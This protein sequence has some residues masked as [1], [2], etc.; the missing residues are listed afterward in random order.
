MARKRAVAPW[1]VGAAIVVGV[2]VCFS[3][4]LIS[5]VFGVNANID[6]RLS[7]FGAIAG[8]DIHT[9]HTILLLLTIVVTAAML[10]QTAAM[11]FVIGVTTMRGRRTEVALRR[12]SGVLRS[13]LIAEFSRSML[14]A[15]V[16][17]GVVG[18]LCGIVLGG[19]LR[20][21]T[22]LPVTFMP[23]TLLAPFPVTVLI[24]VAATIWP[25]WLAANASPALLRKQ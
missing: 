3:V 1:Q 4:L 11:T 23:I 7:G 24:A 6:S 5:V 21:W 16:T 13:T 8:L 9:I 14:V 12:Q 19:A 25:A 15:C 18:E 2:G 20:T 17:G 22:V 10:F